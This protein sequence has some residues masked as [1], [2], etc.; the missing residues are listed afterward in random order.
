MSL[1]FETFGWRDGHLDDIAAKVGRM[2]VIQLEPRSSLYR[3]EYYRWRGA[4]A[5]D[6]ILQ[7]NFVEEDDGLRTDDEFPDHVV[8]LYASNLPRRWFE[9]IATIDGA[10]RLGS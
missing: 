1:R 5:A 8:L 6:L 10:E 4:G 2:L 7:D 9:R 3:G